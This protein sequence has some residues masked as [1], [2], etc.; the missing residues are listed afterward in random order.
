[1]TFFYITFLYHFFVCK[2]V[3]TKFT[4]CGQVGAWTPQ[5]MW[6]FCQMIPTFWRT[7]IT[8]N[9]HTPWQGNE[10]ATLF[11]TG[12][13]PQGE[14]K[15]SPRFVLN[16]CDSTSLLQEFQFIFQESFMRHYFILHQWWNCIYWTSCKTTETSCYQCFFVAS[17]YSRGQE[18]QMEDTKIQLSQ[19]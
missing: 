2:L 7:P 16:P 12:G 18:L 13:L 17:H 3:W 5:G 1:M 15:K 6:H 9:E 10:I 19:Y 8:V 11:S 14:K 4:V